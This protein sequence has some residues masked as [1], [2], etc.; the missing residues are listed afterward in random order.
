MK[1]PVKYAQE[2]IGYQGIDEAI[3]IAKVYVQLNEVT[4]GL[5]ASEK[6]G[7]TNVPGIG[8]EIEIYAEQ[9]LEKG[10]MVTKERVRINKKLRDTRLVANNAFWINV[11]GCVQNKKAQATARAL[12]KTF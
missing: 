5:A 7:E 2:L 3:R 10:K 11:L 1:D 4:F 9:V 6:Q 12:N 8:E